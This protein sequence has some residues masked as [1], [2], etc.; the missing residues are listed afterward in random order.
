MKIVIVG[1]GKIG[2]AIVKNASMENHEVIV[3]DD[4]PEVIERIVNQ[5]D[6]LGIC[7]N[8]V[9]Y[10]MQKASGT[11]TADLFIAVTTSDEANMLA[12][13]IAKKLGAK[14]TIARVRD[15]E[16]TKQIELMTDALGITRTINP[17]HEASKEIMRIINF[18]EAIKVDSFAH[19]SADL[20][21]LYI[22]EDSELVGQSLMNITSKL[23]VPI[24]VCAVQRGNEVI[25]PTGKFV[26]E[27]KDKIHVISSQ[28]AS[29]IL[30]NK[31]G[32][33]KSKLK[34]I[35]IIGAGKITT[36]LA[37]SLIKNNFNVKIIEIDPKKAKE[38]AEL[39]PKATV[40]VGDGSDQ[41]LLREE[42]M[43]DSDAVICLTGID[44]ENIIISLYANK[45]F[46]KKII[47]KVN[48]AS[49]AGLLESIEMGSV[50]SPQDLAAN[51]IISY[52]RG[53]SN[54]RGSNILTLY[55]LV[56]NQVEVIEFL[57]SDSSKVLNVP[58]KD[59]ELKKNI[60]IGGIIRNHKVIIP[61][62]M[63]FIE[64][65]DSVIVVSKEALND[66]D[67]ILM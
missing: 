31:L 23:G 66:L 12:C 50:I 34:D 43:K 56:D 54:T 17:E 30:V 59:L 2:S 11:A 55:K 22:Q 16:Y 48:R 6:V 61:S 52:I 62:G 21:E 1:A 13:L 4:N 39:L 20:T 5:F 60:L 41:N 10:E 38:L 45:L 15:Y 19:G 36:Y 8:G 29:R 37:D 65:G 53:S 47:T 63:S 35:M 57:A 26:F 40:I 9:S 18:P 25:I 67:E 49:F 33:S 7:G 14:N 46:V 64:K 32:L 58:L 24:L 51:Q 3:I 44:E 28:E 42:G 27:A